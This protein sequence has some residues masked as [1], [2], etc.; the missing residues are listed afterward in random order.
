MT[1]ATMMD[2]PLTTQM[3]MRRGERL[4][5]QSEVSTFDGEQLHR[6]SF[7]EI[8][9]RAKR[10]ASALVS[11]GIGPG[12]RVGTLCWNSGSHL[13]AYLAVPAIG[14]VLL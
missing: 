1:D 7:G 14:R 9:D 5:A 10:L 6:L 2:F 4:F 8:A 3:L 11:L 13:A 12:E